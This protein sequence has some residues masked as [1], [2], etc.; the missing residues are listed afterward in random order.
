MVK[1]DFRKVLPIVGIL[2]LSLM[3]SGEVLMAQGPPS[4]VGQPQLFITEVAV[5]NG[6]LTI[7]GENFD[8]GGNP[9][10]DL[11]EYRGLTV[12]PGFT[13]TQIIADC[14]SSVCPEGEFIL[15]VSTGASNNNFDEFDLT[16]EFDPTVIDSVKDGV[17]WTE[18]SGIPG[19]FADGTDDGLTTETDPV[20]G[21]STAASIIGTDVSNWN[22]AYG[23]GDHSSAGYLTSYI[24]T[25]PTVA[26]SV[27]DGVDWT[28]LSGIPGGFADGVDNTG[29][30]TDWVESGG[31]VYRLTGNVGI[32]TIPNEFKLQVEGDIGPNTD[33]S[34]ALGSD[35]YRFTDLYLIGDGCCPLLRNIHIGADSN[36]EARISY[37][38]VNNVLVLDVIAPDAE[39]ITLGGDITSA[40]MTVDKAR[41]NV[42]IGTTSPANK[43][44]VKG[45]TDDYIGFFYNDNNASGNAHG[46]EAT[47]NAIDTGNGIGT[48]GTFRGYGGSTSGDARGSTNYAYAYGSSSAIGVYSD[49]TLGSTTGR[50]YAFYGIGD[51]YISGD[52]GVG[53]LTPLAK[54]DVAGDIR[55]DGQK[56]CSVLIV[57]NWR[58]TVLVPSTWSATTCADYKDAVL[59]NDYQLVCVFSNSFSLGALNGGIPPRNCGW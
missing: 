40:V 47:G 54:L 48:G 18:L 12:Q 50:E 16:I 10:V 36:D 51:S 1:K 9:V 42:G 55:F 27:K 7:T 33:S 35:V 17:D 31:N 22:T 39:R 3:L 49:G 11:G 52:V 56:Y 46:I 24:E 25:D 43:L 26:A 41:G 45:G 29:G 58:N 2:F 59:A 6:T 38:Y 20:F 21:S 34:Y 15:T 28:E 23:W 19:G 32:G 37:D 8:N 5:S 30:D 4:G 57:G 14:P 44:Y 53:V 13:A